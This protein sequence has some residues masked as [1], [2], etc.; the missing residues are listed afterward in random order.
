M[1]DALRLLFSKIRSNADVGDCAVYHTLGGRVD[2]YIV[3]VYVADFSKDFGTFRRYMGTRANVASFAAS[4]HLPCGAVISS[5]DALRVA[6]PK[7]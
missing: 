1:V 5:G 4:A 7:C 2:Y 6:A 3:T